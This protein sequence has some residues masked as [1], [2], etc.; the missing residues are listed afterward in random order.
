MG[1]GVGE[2]SLPVRCSKKIPLPILS[3]AGGALPVLLGDGER[4]FMVLDPRIVSPGT[5]KWNS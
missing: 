4:T 5:A 1:Q 3:R 2:Q